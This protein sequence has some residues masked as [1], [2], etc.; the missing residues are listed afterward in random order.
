MPAAVSQP[1]S[2]SARP[3]DPRPGGLADGRVGRHGASLR[4]AGATSPLLVRL[5]GFT[6]YSCTNK[7][8]KAE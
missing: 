4:A 1:L 7:K 6:H 2:S 3:A 8:V 5:Y